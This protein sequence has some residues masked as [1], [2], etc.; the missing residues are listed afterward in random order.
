M[1]L[2]VKNLH[3]SV[4]DTRDVGSIPGSGRFPWRR[5]QKPIPV[6]L[7]GKSH[8]QRSCGGLQSMGLQRVGYAQ[9]YQIITLYILNL[10]NVIMSIIS[11]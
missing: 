9:V 1:A 4:G 3:A 10:Y 5:A 11:Q 2:V 6:F 8:G 7:P